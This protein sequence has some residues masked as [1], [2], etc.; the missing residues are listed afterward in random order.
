MKIKQGDV[1]VCGPE[2]GCGIKVVVIEACEELDCDLKCCG[3]N[4]V[5]AQKQE[6]PDVW[7]QYRK[8]I[9]TEGWQKHAT[10]KKK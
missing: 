9:E 2:A 3:K 10:P 4:M 6:N 7:K 5:L 8:E 1:L